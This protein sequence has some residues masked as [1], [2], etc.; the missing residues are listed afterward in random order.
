VDDPKLTGRRLHPGVHFMSVRVNKEIL[1]FIHARQRMFIELPEI[2]LRTVP[3][4]TF[5]PVTVAAVV[6][7]AGSESIQG[8][9]V[10]TEVAFVGLSPVK[11][12]VIPLMQVDDAREISSLSVRVTACPGDAHLL[13]G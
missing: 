5:N 10:S 8:A 6:S 13:A 9:P 3:Q 7:A 12:L 4:A 2:Q 11:R 1:H